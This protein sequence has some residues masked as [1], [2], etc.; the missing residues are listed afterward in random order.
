MKKTITNNNSTKKRHK[1]QDRPV[2]EDCSWYEYKSPYFVSDLTE[3][4]GRCLIANTE[5]IQWATPASL[6]ESYQ[7]HDLG[8]VINEIEHLWDLTSE[9]K[10][11]S[12][13]VHC[14]REIQGHES[15]KKAIGQWIDILASE[16]PIKQAHEFVKKH[17]VSTGKYAN[18][19]FFQGGEQDA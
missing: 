10:T 1:Y 19:C 18:I 9:R 8:Y 2:P 12:F 11:I 17:G 4:K 13:L 5:R 15:L 14:L 3:F 6:V 7:K 16:T